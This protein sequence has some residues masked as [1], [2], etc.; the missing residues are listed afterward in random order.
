M[1][2]QLGIEKLSMFSGWHRSK[3]RKTCHYTL[4]G[5][6]GAGWMAVTLEMD[7]GGNDG[8]FPYRQQHWNVWLAQAGAQGRLRAKYF[9]D[10]GDHVEAGGSRDQRSFVVLDAGRSSNSESMC[11]ALSPRILTSISRRITNKGYDEFPHGADGIEGW[12]VDFNM[13]LSSYKANIQRHN[14]RS[15]L[16]FREGTM[17]DTWTGMVRMFLV[18]VFGTRSITS[19]SAIIFKQVKAANPGKLIVVADVKIERNGETGD[20]VTRYPILAV[21]GAQGVSDAIRKG[22]NIIQLILADNR[23]V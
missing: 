5:Y 16:V 19:S 18:V 8:V 13:G 10:A 6:N 22:W 3:Q 11:P 4:R 1:F 15:I 17:R 9:F 2:T 23:R 21:S 12:L 7:A 20:A 14:T